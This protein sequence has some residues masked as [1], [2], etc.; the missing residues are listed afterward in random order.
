MSQGG[1]LRFCGYLLKEG[2]EFAHL[3]RP[4][5][6]SRS[7]GFLFI[8]VS[9]RRSNRRLKKICYNTLM[10]LRQYIIVFAIGTSIAFASWLIVLFN[11]DPVTASLPVFLS[12]FLTLFIGFVG[13]FTTLGTGVRAVRF[14]DRDV[15]E[16]VTTSLRQGLLLSSVLT[17]STFLLS[18]GYFEWWVSLI[19]IVVLAG[20]EFFFHKNTSKTQ[21]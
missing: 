11:I 19:M 5:L 14:P 18:R 12:F 6:L 1:T 4:L 16:T 9:Q 21:S 13:F 15:E 7:G 8:R 10:N 3:N 17:A 2:E 20:L